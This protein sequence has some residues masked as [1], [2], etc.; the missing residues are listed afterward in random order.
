[1][2]TN[3]GPDRSHLSLRNAM[4]RP[5]ARGATQKRKGL[6]AATTLGPLF[7]PS[8]PGKK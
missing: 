2:K 8:Q 7:L 1:M 3:P 5:G 6:K 4:L